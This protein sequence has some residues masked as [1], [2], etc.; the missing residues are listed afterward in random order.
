MATVHSEPKGTKKAKER[1]TINACSNASGS[2][3]LPLLMIDKAKNPRCFSGINK[4]TLTVLYR[5]QTNAWVNTLKFK[6]W[7]TSCF[8]PE[9]K[10]K[11]KVIGQEI[12]IIILDNCAALP[13]EEKLISSDGKI[14]VTFLL[15]N[16]T[17]LIQP[18]DQSVL[19]A[20][21]RVDRKSIFKRCH[22]EAR[23]K[24]CRCP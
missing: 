1:V 12:T 2:I 22:I 10:K 21:K 15:K 16:V 11:L 13:G 24:Y 7:F 19:E 18:M 3:K 5:N 4:E 6:D 23:Q 14:V 20:L 9:V 8:V 17:V